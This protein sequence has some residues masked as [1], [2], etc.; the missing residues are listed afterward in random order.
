[1][2]TLG[3]LAIAMVGVAAIVWGAET[4]A[5]HLSVASARLGV[6]TFALAILLAGAEPEELATAV[7][8]SL[9]GAPGIALGDVIGANV[10][11]CLV[12]LGVGAVLA[13][14]PFDRKVRRYALAGIPAGLLA[15][16]I[17]WDGSVSR[18]EGIVL[19]AAYVVFVA[20]IWIIERQPPALGETGE[21]AEAQEAAGSER[22]T[23]RVGRELGLVLAGVAAMAVGASALV[24]GIRRISDVEATQTRLGLVVVG[25]AT[26]FEL[27]VLAWSSA[28]RGI[29]TAVV[30]GVIG[31][32]TYNVTMT[33]GAGALARPLRISDPELLHGPWAAMLAALAVVIALGWRPR[34]IGRFGGYL[35][36]GLYPLFVLLVLAL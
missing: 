7:T 33:L 1:M 35:L 5:E 15:A 25:F 36:L 34:H 21:L 3:W 10:A 31:S 13:P 30:A 20:T 23:R 8:A 28:R 6:S 27:V 24:E 9:R 17:A 4:F 26:A 22:H 11:I 32:Y 2:G 16:V 14:L 18:I 19:V 29:T 12:A